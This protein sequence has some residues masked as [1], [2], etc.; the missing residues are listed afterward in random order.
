MLGEQRT[1]QTALR[2]EIKGHHHCAAWHEGGLG[3][4]YQGVA[5]AQRYGGL[6]HA[7]FP[8]D[9]AN[10]LTHYA[11]SPRASRS[12]FWQFVAL[13]R[14]DR[15]SSMF[16][17]SGDRR[18]ASSTSSIRSSRNRPGG[19]ATMSKRISPTPSCT[20]ALLMSLLSAGSTY[21]RGH[22]R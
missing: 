17:G 21:D 12:S 2:V 18:T 19:T 6:P 4:T 1:R 9:Y 3:V 10:D 13:S 15:C 8:I 7:P 14:L 20:H 16:C 11:L 5:D 22:T